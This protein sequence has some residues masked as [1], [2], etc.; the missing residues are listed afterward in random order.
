MVHLPLSDV[1]VQVRLLLAVARLVPLGALFTAGHH[2]EPLVDALVVVP[3][4]PLLIRLARFPFEALRG[5]KRLAVIQTE[6]DDQRR[7]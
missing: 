2:P 7:R 1:L 6:D 4:G 5:K 3:S